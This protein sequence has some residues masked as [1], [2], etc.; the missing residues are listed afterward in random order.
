[1]NSATLPGA[2]IDKTASTGSYLASS[3][4]GVSEA[5]LLK[6]FAKEAGISCSHLTRRLLVSK[7]IELDQRCAKA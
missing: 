3:R 5:E 1:M 7:L 4:L 6:K 2:V